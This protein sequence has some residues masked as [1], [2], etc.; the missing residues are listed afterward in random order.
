[1]KKRQLLLLCCIAAA[2]LATVLLVLDYLRY[3][4]ARENQSVEIGTAAGVRVAD[5]LDGILFRLSERAAR[6]A[7]E[8]VALQSEDELLRSI[9]EESGRFPHILGV[10]VAF[11][12]GVFQGRDRFAPFFNNQRKEFQFVESSYDY[13]DRQLATAGWYTR[14]IDQRQARWTEPYYGEAAQAMVVDY[15]VPLPGAGGKPVGVVDYT[16]TLSELA[17][18]AE[19]L[20]VGEAGY[21]FIYE[22][23][24]VI[25]SH[26]NSDVILDNVYELRDGKN[27]AILDQMREQSEGIVSYFSTYT[28]LDSRFFFRELASTGWKSVLVFAEDD[29]LGRTAEHK[30]K[31]IHIVICASATLILL[32][33]L[34]LSR[35]KLSPAGL[36]GLVAFISLV[37]VGNILATWYINPRADYSRPNAEQERIVNHSILEKYAAGFDEELYKLDQS[38][39]RRVPTGIYIESF[40]L[41]SFEVSLIG[42]LWMKYPRDLY[43]VAPPAFYMPDVSALEPRGMMS[44]LVSEV[45]KE[46]HILVTWNFRATLEQRFSYRQYPFDENNIEILVVYP[47]FSS[48]ILL[49]PDLDSYVVL[50]PPLKPGLSRRLNVPSSE[51][52]SSYF[53][54]NVIDPRTTFGDE[55]LT[56]SQPALGFNVVVKRI[57]LSPFI[58]NIIPI[59]IVAAILFIVL[60]ISSRRADER[61]GLTIMNVVQSAA[62]FMFILVLAHVNER[63]RIKTPEIAYIELFYFAMYAF[64]TLIT[65]VVALMLK[66][67]PSRF[68]RGEDN[69]PV[70]LLYWPILLSTWYGLTLL[71]FY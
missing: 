62:G 48:N 28:F 30:R 57:F 54:F 32:L 25:L 3:Q 4:Q 21:G 20:S 16:I 14:A 36:W 17:M 7:V 29:L 38:R 50:N 10:T 58:A 41:T 64:V 19:S 56:R 42:R 24:G 71:R 60:F 15:V 37:I 22:P 53:T 55:S 69:L 47:D 2:L 26:P 65:V 6:Y 33:L 18:I 46:D 40:E 23:N 1:L 59:L 63:G 39:Y 45:E 51:T 13:T 61:S 66:D 52:L 5:A 34:P 35:G 44:T 49:V 31:A 67:H 8:V 27:Q 68:F 70:K 43:E 11:E 9:R 12:P